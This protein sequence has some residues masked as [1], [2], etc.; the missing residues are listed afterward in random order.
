MGRRSMTGGVKPLGSHRIQLDFRIEG[1]R[2]RPS[3][4]WI[5]HD[6]NLRRARDYLAR[7]K[8]RIDGGTFLFSEA[9][10][11]FSTAGKRVPLPLSAR[12]CDGVFD[13]F[14]GHEAARVARDDLAPSTLAAH[15][16]ILDHI[17]RP[18][19]GALSILAVRYTE[20]V[21][22]ADSH[23]WTKK[24]Y[25]N[26]IS[27]L[28]RAFAFGFEDHPEL[29]NPARALKSAR[30]QSSTLVAGVPIPILD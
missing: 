16:Q 15:R 30:G 27:A 11:G 4:P 23:R 22:I 10:P 1:V 19:I 18:A 17:W 7:V 20:L 24:T 26:A 21:K 14:L 28:R 12:T 25:N 3:L 6:G 5:P 29:H 2:Y 13:A 9:F 8:A